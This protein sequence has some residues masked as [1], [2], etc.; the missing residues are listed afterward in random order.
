VS[1]A[2]IAALPRGNRPAHMRALESFTVATTQFQPEVG[3][4]LRQWRERRRLTQLDLALDAG[5]SARH[6]SFVETGR[7]KPGREMLLRVLE[8]LEVPFREQNRLLLSA[9]HAP[10]FPERS[11][12][13]SELAPVRKALEVILSGHEPF[14]AVAVDR[15]WNL[16]AANSAMFALTESVDIDPVLLEPP[17]NVIRVGL[18]PRGLGPRFVNLGYWHRHWVRRLERQ[19]VATGDEQLA[20]LIDEITTFPVPRARNDFGSEVADGEMLGPVSVRTPKGGELSFFGMFATFDT[21]FEVT[22]SELAVEFLFPADQTT[23]ETL[24][25]RGRQ[26][27]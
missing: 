8:Q 9:G 20:A 13:D 19:L 2:R 22:T 18:H 26:H 1:L 6:L 24:Q 14:P 25:K 7:S 3:H 16:V 23:A 11:L 5:I 15:V 17:I 27:S 10:A 21:P 4:L 12:D